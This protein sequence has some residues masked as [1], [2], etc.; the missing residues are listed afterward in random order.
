MCK[1]VRHNI[2]PV[3]TRQQIVLIC[4]K[5]YLSSKVGCALVIHGTIANEDKENMEEKRDFLAP[6]HTDSSETKI[7]DSRPR[8]RLQDLKSQI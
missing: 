5:M 6:S 4:T 1:V 7:G 8:P 3:L 2:H